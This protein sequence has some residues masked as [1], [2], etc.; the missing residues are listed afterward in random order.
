MKLE[1]DMKL[2]NRTSISDSVLKLILMDAKRSLGKSINTNIL[3]RVRFSKHGGGYIM[4]NVFRIRGK[5]NPKNPDKWIYVKNGAVMEVT[6]P[7]NHFTDAITSAKRFYETCQHE[8]GH[9]YDIQQNEKGKVGFGFAGN[10]NKRRT[11]HSLRPEEMRVEE[12][13]NNPKVKRFDSYEA[14]MMLAIEI[15]KIFK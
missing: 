10:V 8:W 13:V 1:N 12:Y 2:I 7:K 9:V 15:E 6:I 14:I 4:T 3:I 11:K 5:W